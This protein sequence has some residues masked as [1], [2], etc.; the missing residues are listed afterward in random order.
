M[1]GLA[2]AVSGATNSVTSI[3]GGTIDEVHCIKKKSTSRVVIMD[4]SGMVIR[5]Q[6]YVFNNNSG[7]T[8]M[9][10]IRNTYEAGKY[11]VKR[12]R[13]DGSTLTT[14]YEA[15]F[16]ND[17]LDYTI[18]EVG[19]KVTYTYDASGRVQTKKRI[20][21]DDATENFLDQVDLT[22]TYFYDADGNLTKTEVKGQGIDEKIV[23]EYEYDKAKRRTKM[24]ERGH[25]S[26]RYN[27]VYTYETCS[28]D[29]TITHPDG[30]DEVRT[31]F[32]DGKPETITGTAV[33]NR[34]FAYE[35]LTSE[36]HEGYLSSKVTYDESG[37]GSDDQWEEIYTDWLGRTARV[38][39]PTHDGGDDV[40]MDYSYDSD[41]LLQKIETTSGTTATAPNRLYAYDALK[42]LYREAVDT[43]NDGAI[44][45]GQGQDRVTEY[46][47]QYEY[48][49]GQSLGWWRYEDAHLY[50]DYGTGAPKLTK[51]R[52]GYTRLSGFDGKSWVSTFVD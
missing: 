29:L 47:Y 52:Y 46:T 30:S 3:N 24:I 51:V 4:P 34:L 5:T 13:V 25:G 43:D 38:I 27:T 2:V 31:F 14:L 20:G 1:R 49:T 32:K 7:W 37:S 39:R 9:A 15:K 35:I 41:G 48:R 33:P 10:A 22:T 17:Q 18:D 45:T 21:W 19:T 6:D 50:N 11:L 42:V 28:N 36:D 8:G 40:H 23:T 26:E 12:E 16:V 44:G